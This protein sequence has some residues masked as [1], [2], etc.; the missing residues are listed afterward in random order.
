M[1]YIMAKH[2]LFITMGLK[3]V[4]CYESILLASKVA[5]SCCVFVFSMFVWNRYTTYA[6]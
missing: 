4:F 3:T 2:F 1:Y 6:G 5:I